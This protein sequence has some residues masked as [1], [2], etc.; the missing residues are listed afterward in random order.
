MEVPWIGAIE[1]YL[2]LPIFKIFG[3]SIY[4]LRIT[5][6]FFTLLIGLLFG[7]LCYLMFNGRVWCI[8]TP[9]ILFNAVYLLQGR[10]AFVASILVLWASCALCLLLFWKWVKSRKLSW[11]YLSAFVMGLGTYGKL[12]FLWMSFGIVF[13]WMF[14][15]RSQYRLTLRGMNIF[16]VFLA[17]CLGF[18]PYIIQNIRTQGSEIYTLFR[19]FLNPGHDSNNLAYFKHLIIRFM[20]VGEALRGIEFYSDKLWLGWLKMMPIASL[21]VLILLPRVR[22]R[23]RAKKNPLLFLLI[24]I[25]VFILGVAFSGTR[26]AG[27]HVL[28]ILPLILICSA[29]VLNA[30]IRNRIYLILLVFFM[31]IPDFFIIANYPTPERRWVKDHVAEFTVE[32]SDYLL[33]QGLQNPIMVN[34]YMLAPTIAMLTRGRVFPIEARPDVDQLIEK[35]GEWMNNR[36]NVYI[37]YKGS[38]RSYAREEEEAKNGYAIFKSA[39]QDNKRRIYVL[40]EFSPDPDTLVSV[41]KVE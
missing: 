1:S 7:Y 25:L 11:L 9:L 24:C 10:T 34:H 40:K 6:I 8:A 14:L 5:E 19:I 27:I 41:C 26:L 37:L 12:H 32:F 13:G 20:Q 38:A 15:L 21:I 22:E 4:T 3:V 2:M 23:L 33:S 30:L 29:V 31:L 36:K 28:P 18:L 39:L 17:W 35:Y 16:K